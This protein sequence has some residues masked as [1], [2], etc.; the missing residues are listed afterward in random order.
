MK[1]ECKGLQRNMVLALLMVF[2][3]TM[4]KGNPIKFLIAKKALLLA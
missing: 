1:V 2:E 3:K 4:Q